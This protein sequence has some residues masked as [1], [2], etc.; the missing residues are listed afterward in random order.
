MGSSSVL[1]SMWPLIQQE[2]AGTCCSS[3][4]GVARTIKRLLIEH[5]IVAEG[6]GAVPV[7]AALS[8]SDDPSPAVCIVSGGHLDPEHLKEILDDRVPSA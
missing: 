1:G 2:I 7:A 4:E 6:A 3:L 8:V 5:H